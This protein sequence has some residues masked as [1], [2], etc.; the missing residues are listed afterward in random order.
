M[1]K[2]AKRSIQLVVHASESHSCKPFVVIVKNYD[3]LKSKNKDKN[4]QKN[5]NK[6]LK[7]CF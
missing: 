3:A 4:N 7:R 1:D 6:D 2:L 5:E